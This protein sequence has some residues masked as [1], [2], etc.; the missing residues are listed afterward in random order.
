MSKKL[1][2]VTC[3]LPLSND[4]DI[5]IA[6]WITHHFTD[7]RS[8][9][10]TPFALEEIQ[11]K[12]E[13]EI[14]TRF[15]QTLN[16]TIIPVQPNQ[17]LP[18]TLLERIDGIF[19]AHDSL[20][21]IALERELPY[22]TLHNN[23]TPIPIDILAITAP[24]S[25][26]STFKTCIYLPFNSGLQLEKGLLQLLGTHPATMIVQHQFNTVTNDELPHKNSEEWSL[27][28]MIFQPK[29]ETYLWSAHDHYALKPGHYNYAAL[30]ILPQTMRYSIQTDEDSGSITRWYSDNPQ[31]I[32]LSIRADYKNPHTP[33]ISIPTYLQWFN[34]RLRI[35]TP[36]SEPTPVTMVI[37]NA[38]VTSYPS[39]NEHEQH[40]ETTAR[41]DNNTH[42]QRI[43]TSFNEAEGTLT[44]RAT[45]Q[46]HAHIAYYPPYSHSRHCQLIQFAQSLPFCTST[47]LGQSIEGRDI[48]V[49]QFGTPP[50]EKIRNDVIFIMAR[51]HP[52]ETH[53]EWFIEG[54]I[55]QFARNESLELLERA[56]LY[57]VPNM[58]P[59]GTFHGNHRTNAAGMDLNRAWLDPNEQVSPEVLY[60]R[61]LIE[62]LRPTVILDIH[63]EEGL[64]KV[65]P[66]GRVGCTPNPLLDQRER[67]L[68][69]SL[70]KMTPVL[71]EKSC[72]E[73]FLP[74]EEDFSLATFYLGEHQRLTALVLEMPFKALN[75]TQDWTIEDCKAFGGN[76]LRAISQYL[77][78]LDILSISE[79]RKPNPSPFFESTMNSKTCIENTIPPTPSHATHDERAD[80]VRTLT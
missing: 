74:G 40:Y 21:A 25:Q 67:L 71:E 3:P 62:S 57:I 45:I 36:S 69:E 53:A 80:N 59:D 26:T 51:Q 52:G 61:R 77:T 15:F 47:T 32:H 12:I 20:K 41:L 44:M 56:V 79:R 63:S 42:W 14:V 29:E 50:K 23:A 64:S 2:L 70:K 8:I 37:Q 73:P 22:C 28:D 31:H 78:Q 18:D 38:G 16:I 11:Q 65:F 60:V 7:V 13:T 9:L 58:N 46:S 4:F 5:D 30:M 10:Y 17:H 6:T 35:I 75:A 39:W 76:T 54:L 72:Y 43:P 1:L 24:M 66:D 48:T 33:E 68:I 55:N 34:F 19:S 27:R 49:L